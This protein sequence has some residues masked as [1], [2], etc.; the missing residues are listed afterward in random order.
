MGLILQERRIYLHDY[1]S[2]QA[3]TEAWQDIGREMQA[4]R[5]GPYS[6]PAYNFDYQRYLP[7]A[8][9]IIRDFYSVQDDELIPAVRLVAQLKADSELPFLHRLAHDRTLNP[10]K[11]SRALRHIHDLNRFRCWRAWRRKLPAIAI[12]TSN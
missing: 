7:I 5:G 9:R 8:Q 6:K 4:L 10:A 3:G 1:V 12:S 2:G 11:K